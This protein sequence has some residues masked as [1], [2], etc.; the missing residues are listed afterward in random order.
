MILK[1]RDR[2]SLLA[3]QKL[4]QEKIS[5]NASYIPL[6]NTCFDK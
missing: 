1:V 6:T 4:L 3:L 2:I 5:D